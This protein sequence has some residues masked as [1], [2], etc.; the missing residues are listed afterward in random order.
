MSDLRAV[1]VGGS[2]ATG[3]RL[4]RLLT[5]CDAYRTVVL[6]NRRQLEFDQKPGIEK[7]E[8]RIVD[9]DAITAHQKEFDGASVVFCAL[10]TTRAQAG[11]AGFYKVDHDYVV[12]CARAAK[13][14][15]VP[16]FC[17]VSS[18][19]ADEKSSFL[20]VRTKG[21]MERDVKALD[22][23][24]CTIA[25]PAFL[26]GA[27]EKPRFMETVARF[28]LAPFSFFFPTKF[29]IPFESLAKAMIYESLNLGDQKL[30]ILDNAELHRL[31]ALYD[32]KYS[33]KSKGDA[34]S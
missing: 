18:V 4:I 15:G 32:Q 27:R 9:F 33:P 29:A 10:G 20:Y 26:E 14:A 17:V 13:A 16:H 24:H 19:G 23:A 3:S 5:T 21:E 7:F 31:A 25:R 11:A 6:L 22:F 12:E 8:Q 34:A 2:G 1:V 28:G 30:R